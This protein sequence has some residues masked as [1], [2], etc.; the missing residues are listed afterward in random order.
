[1]RQNAI[2]FRYR[3]FWQSY[4]LVKRDNSTSPATKRQLNNIQIY[5]H[6][7]RR[8][9]LGMLQGK[10]DYTKNTA[11]C[12]ARIRGLD[13]LIN[14]IYC[15]GRSKSKY[16]RSKATT[17]YWKENITKKKQ[18]KKSNAQCKRGREVKHRNKTVNEGKLNAIIQT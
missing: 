18:K 6:G 1:M 7:G 12:R 14:P 3:R 10:N 4:V 15:G 8:L 17:T 11:N 16:N 5:P 9:K 2:S 13:N